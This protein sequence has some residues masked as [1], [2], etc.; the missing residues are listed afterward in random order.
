MVRDSAGEDTTKNNNK[1]SI[2]DHPTSS[3]NGDW[4]EDHCESTRSDA[5][6]IEESSQEQPQL[7]RS[8]RERWPSTRYNIDEYVTLTDEKEP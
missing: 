2:N 4:E 5:E 6:S 1:T 7:R 3:S 8:T